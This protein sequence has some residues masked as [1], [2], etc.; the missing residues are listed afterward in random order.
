VKR[1]VQL[2]DLQATSTIKAWLDRPL[3]REQRILGWILSLSIFIG[4]I[5]LLGGPTSSDSPES[6]YST[7]SIAHGSFACAYPHVKTLSAPLYP[8]LSGGLAWLLRIGGSV[9]FPSAAQLGPHCAT[10][11]SAIYKW[12]V[13]SGALQRTLQIG[14][15]SWLALMV[16]LVAFLRTTL[17]GGR[18]W[19]PF[20][21]VAMALSLPTLMPLIEE[22]HPQDILATGLSLAALASVRRGSW[23]WAGVLIGLAF[24]SQQFVLLVAAPLLV[25]A[26][27]DRRLR[28]SLAAIGTVATVALPLLLLTSG[29]ALRAIVV[30]TGLSP[31]LGRT[32]LVETDL[33]GSLLNYISRAAPIVAALAL[34]LWAR[35]RV[36]PAA[37]GA[38]FLISLLALSLCFRLVFELN[39]YGYYFMPL[40]VLLILLDVTRGSIRGCTIAWLA[41]VTLVFNPILFYQFANGTTYGLGPF[42]GIQIAFL[43]IA[44]LLIAYDALLPRIRW[45]LVAWFILALTAFVRK[46][47]IFG[48]SHTAFA[49]W[50]WQIVLL[51]TGAGLAAVPFVEASRQRSRPNLV[52]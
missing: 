17:R 40:G 4:L 7:W 14:D 9:H 34:S 33:H 37:L 49:V 12:S 21:L 50:F 48:P 26:P 30:G 8:L 29:R 51:L 1:Q 28:F 23:V 15:V 2:F 39:L 35:R 47:W 24:T 13:K 27:S 52:S 3:S 25:V 38:D 45:Y 44:F 41:M 31:S 43:S 19:E 6:V 46:G 42:R 16:G 5:A 36:G 32:L 10:A 22:F 18:V 20:T 11:F